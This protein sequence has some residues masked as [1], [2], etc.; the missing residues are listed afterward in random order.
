MAISGPL[1][2]LIDT[3]PFQKA[4]TAQ[5][6]RELDMDLGGIEIYYH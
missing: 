4:E 3:I 1:L 5:R 6:L 2:D